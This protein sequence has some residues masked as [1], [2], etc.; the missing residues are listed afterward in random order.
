MPRAMAMIFIWLARLGFLYYAFTAFNRP[1]SSGALP[2]FTIL[3]FQPPVSSLRLLYL[4]HFTRPIFIDA[5]T[6]LRERRLRHFRDSDCYRPTTALPASHT[7]ARHEAYATSE[8]VAVTQ[9]FA[10]AHA[11][12]RRRL[13]LRWPARLIEL[14]Y[15][16]RRWPSRAYAAA[17]RESRDF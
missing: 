4:R 16:A 17:S 8:A 5:D 6:A 14:R 1:T 11:V 13:C 12:A 3:Y 2:E 9:Y 15:A 10:N 7:A